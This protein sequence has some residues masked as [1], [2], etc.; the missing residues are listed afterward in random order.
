MVRTVAMRLPRGMSLP[1]EAYA[2]SVSDLPSVTRTASVPGTEE[3][4]EV[5]TARVDPDE[6]KKIYERERK[7]KYRKQKQLEQTAN[8]K[9]RKRPNPYL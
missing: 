8:R 5:R 3:T 9:P 7:R 1:A 6:A 4:T 2:W